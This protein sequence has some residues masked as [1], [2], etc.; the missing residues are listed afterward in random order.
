MVLLVL[1]QK[2]RTKPPPSLIQ[3]VP[4]KVL[5]FIRQESA[6]GKLWPE[7]TDAPCGCFDESD[8]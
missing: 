7:L 6:Q 8:E 4:M 1:V 2:Y 5:D 3:A